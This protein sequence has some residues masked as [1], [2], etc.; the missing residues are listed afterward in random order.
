MSTGVDVFTNRV[1]GVH[2]VDSSEPHQPVR[3]MID[4]PEP[5]VMPGL[6]PECVLLAKGRQVWRTHHTADT[7]VTSRGCRRVPSEP[8]SI[9]PE[10]FERESLVLGGT[11]H[12]PLQKKTRGVRQSP[13]A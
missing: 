3:Y 9:G 5:G 7:L 10:K 2:V 8:R 11:R 12:T 6:N 13:V 1:N 4:V